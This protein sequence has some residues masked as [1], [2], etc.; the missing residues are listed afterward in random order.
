MFAIALGSSK[1]N[2]RAKHT[3]SILKKG[4]SDWYV[5]AK[6]T[7]IS[8][9][10]STHEWVNWMIQ[11]P[12]CTTNTHMEIYIYIYISC[13]SYSTWDWKEDEEEKMQAHDQSWRMKKRILF[14]PFG[15][16]AVASCELSRAKDKIATLF[17]RRRRRSR[18]VNL[19]ETQRKAFLTHMHFTDATVSLFR[20]VKWGTGNK[21]CHFFF[22]RVTI[23]AIELKRKNEVSTH[24]QAHRHTYIET[25]EDLQW[26]L[27]L[28][29]GM[30]HLHASDGK[31]SVLS[32]LWPH[33]GRWS[34]DQW[35]SD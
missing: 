35:P 31:V 28:A 30:C 13:V 4:A 5:R 9:V 11:Q 8:R 2:R 6:C 16:F 1:G 3:R 21:W 15:P 20:N 18:R 33:N 7:Q 29:I 24:T 12:K 26:Q 17:P 19:Q 23:Y 32:C 25:P 34:I 27:T 22:F 10:E 14:Y